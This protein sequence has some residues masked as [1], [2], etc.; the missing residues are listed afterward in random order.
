MPIVDTLL[1]L[2]EEPSFYTPKWSPD[3]LQEVRKT[4]EG[5]FGYSPEQVQRRIG[6]M[7][8]TFPDAMVTGYDDLIPVM[9]N[10]LEDRHVLAAAVKCGAH[11]IVSDN[12]KH[13]PAKALSPYNLECLTAHD[14]MTHQYHLNPDAFISVLVEQARDIGWTLP[15]LISKHVPSLSKLIISH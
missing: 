14:F 6:T 11:A 12:V 10:D 4:L 3:I 2:A 8:R 7:E 1:R 15:Q 9:T 5:R 13:F